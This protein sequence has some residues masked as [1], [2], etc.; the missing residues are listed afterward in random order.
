MGFAIIFFASWLITALFVVM[1]K[2][3]SFIENSFVILFALI[4]SINWSWFIYEEWK[5][6]EI[7]SQPLNHTAFLISR[8][9]TI[10]LIIVTTMNLLDAASSAVKSFMIILF[11]VFILALLVVISNYFNITNAI[12]WNFIY[13][14]L[15]LISLNLITYFFLF[16]FRKLSQIEVKV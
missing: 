5:L 14:I 10:P 11:S 8:S 4:I 12:R 1:K 7:S 6:V 9:I 2:K 16:Y 15:Y 3:L 13:D